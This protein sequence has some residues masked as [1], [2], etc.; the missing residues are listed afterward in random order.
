M[1]HQPFENWIFSDQPLDPTDQQAL[2]DHLKS[3]ESCQ[4][5]QSSW[6]RIRGEFTASPMIKPT[7]GFTKRWEL[8]LE[9][10]RRQIRHRQSFVFLGFN[11][12]AVV[13]I[14]LLMAL[15]STPMLRAPNL[16]FWA[17]IYRLL[18][19]AQVWDILQD[20]SIALIILFEGSW[21]V[22]SLLW[23]FP[24]LGS[25]FALSVFWFTS[26]RRLTSIRKV[27]E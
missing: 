26:L 1:K 16:V 27:I 17:S 15:L 18:P 25:I 19:I 3:C 4:G 21:S 11:I 22:L 2:D 9:E 14:V 24:I 13:M 20:L 5:L 7:A 8:H 6:N 12:G 23:F 10:Q